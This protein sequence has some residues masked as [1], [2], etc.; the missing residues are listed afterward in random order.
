ML[1]YSY[2]HSIKPVVFLQG[3]C[4]RDLCKYLHPTYQIKQQLEITG[5]QTLIQNRAMLQQMLPLHQVHATALPQSGLIGYEVW[6]LK[7]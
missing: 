7:F 5:R 6:K 3:K 1:L 2:S 4:N